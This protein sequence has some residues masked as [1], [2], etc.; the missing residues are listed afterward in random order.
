MNYKLFQVAILENAEVKKD[1]E[2]KPP[3]VIIEPV[4][5]VAK[6]EQDAAIRVAMANGEKL[7]GANQ[8]RIEVV[9]RPF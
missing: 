7:N 4:T 5:V 6:N 8:D 2:Q 9:V 1:E 3:K